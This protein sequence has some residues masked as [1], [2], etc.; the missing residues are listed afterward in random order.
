MSDVD[1]VVIGAGAAGL[2]AAR[3]VAAL[4]RPVRVLESRA[5]LGGRAFTSY[6][7]AGSPIELGCG[8]MHS[9][10]ENEFAGLAPG[11]GFTID[12][13][14]PPWRT[15]WNDIGFPP[16]DQQEFVGRPNQSRSSVLKDKASAGA[17]D[18]TSC[19]LPASSSV[20]A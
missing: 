4:G 18:G 19:A 15:Q 13:A 14:P 16:A 11:L 8:W 3:R 5:R 6:D 10:D 17:N 2:A 9:A 1:I 7:F 12:K 20:N